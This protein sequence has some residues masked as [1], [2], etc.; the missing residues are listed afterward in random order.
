MDTPVAPSAYCV[1]TDT[2]KRGCMTG[3]CLNERKTDTIGVI[4]WLLSDW[5]HVALS[6]CQEC[7][8]ARVQLRTQLVLYALHPMAQGP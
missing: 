1:S 6:Q 5:R 8:A 3:C 7:I 2:A 4:N